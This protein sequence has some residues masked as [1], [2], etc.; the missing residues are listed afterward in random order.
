MQVVESV[1]LSFFF[2]HKGIVLPVM[3]SDYIE[4]ECS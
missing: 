1:N 2:N 3:R 4:T